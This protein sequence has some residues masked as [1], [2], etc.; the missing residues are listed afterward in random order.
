MASPPCIFPA[1][2]AYT[3]QYRQKGGRRMEA[4]KILDI[5]DLI[6]Q[7]EWQVSER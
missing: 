3:V 4:K 2:S 7:D 5:D 1:L 6:Y